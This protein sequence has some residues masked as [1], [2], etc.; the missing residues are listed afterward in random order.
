[1]EKLVNKI[2]NQYDLEIQ[3]EL[4]LSNCFML[5]RIE[6]IVVSSGVG[7]LKEDDK[8]IEKIAADLTKI[9][10]QKPKKNLSK[11]AVSAFKLRIGQV[12]GLTVTLR[13]E[14]MYDF[15]DK[16]IN[17][18]LPRVRDFRGLSKKSFDGQGN[19]II[20]IKEHTIF[21]EI[22]LEDVATPFGLQVNIKTNN[23]D[24]EKVQVLL[25]HLGVPFSK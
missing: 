1:M 3:K 23:S 21:P 8:E 17:S 11:K 22:R 4:K 19:Y 2:K 13:G 9:T 15:L 20:G 5:P 14:K 25:K 7:R 16:L 10:G 6:K 12:I 18:A 24:D